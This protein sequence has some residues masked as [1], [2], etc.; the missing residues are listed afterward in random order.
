MTEKEEVLAIMLSNASF[1]FRL[2]LPGC[3]PPNSRSLKPP[4]TFV[5]NTSLQMCPWCSLAHVA[6]TA[7]CS[8]VG[9]CFHSTMFQGPN[10]SGPRVSFLSLVLSTDL[11]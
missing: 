5:S 9:I 4:K 2:G 1:F 8:E 11:L 6:I 7:S 10:E 3:S